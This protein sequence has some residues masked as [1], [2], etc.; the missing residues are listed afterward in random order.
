MPR[1]RAPASGSILYY[2]EPGSPDRATRTVLYGSRKSSSVRPRVWLKRVA[3][4]AALQHPPTDMPTP[5]SS[6][7]RNAT[8]LLSLSQRPSTMLHQNPTRLA[9]TSSPIAERARGSYSCRSLPAGDLT[10]LPTRQLC[11][12]GWLSIRRLS[13]TLR[14]SHFWLM[15]VP[16]RY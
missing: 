15:Q 4:A 13:N 5:C 8:P 16:R 6:C 11:T 14:S 10:L 9:R 2:A 7:C 12:F 3:Y 1:K